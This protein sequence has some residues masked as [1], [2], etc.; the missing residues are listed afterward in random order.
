MQGAVLGVGDT[1]VTRPWPLLIKFSL[2]GKQGPK[3]LLIMI[4]INA[5][6][7]EHWVQ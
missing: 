6:K 5:T 4:V 2:M 3:E 7:E 1:V